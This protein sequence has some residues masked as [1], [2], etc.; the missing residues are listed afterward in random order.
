MT[1]Y[2]HSRRDKGEAGILH[3]TIRER[4]REDEKVVGSPNVRTKLSLQQPSR[5]DQSEVKT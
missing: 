1:T 4:G 5:L 3:P 2:Q